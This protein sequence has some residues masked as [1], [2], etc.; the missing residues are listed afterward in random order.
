MTIDY[1]RAADLLERYRV[2]RET[3][4]GDGWVAIFTEDAEYHDGPFAQP[5]I[6]HNGLRTFLLTSAE[7]QRE[8]DF[9][10]ERHWVSGS[11]VLAAWH[12]SSTDRS[13]GD[14]ARVGGFLTMDIASDG[15][16]DRLRE[17]WMMAP[18]TNG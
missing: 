12:M 14:V 10:V 4:D 7:T 1:A 16:I 15:R 6:G 9:T 13:R 11:T 18:T 3:F 2:A 17:W 8:V 5:F